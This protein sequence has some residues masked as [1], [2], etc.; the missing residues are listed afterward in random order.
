MNTNFNYFADA[1]DYANNN[2]SN[3][4]GGW[5]NFTDQYNYMDNA[6]VSAPSNASPSNSLP[7]V[8][9]IA[10]STASNVTGVVILGA[11][12]N[13]VGATNN[14]N[15]AAITITY[16]SGS[17]TYAQFLENL[18]S[19]P[20]KVGK[21]HLY[22]TN[23]SQ[24]FQTLTFT[25]PEPNGAS[26]TWPMVPQL[27]PLQNLNNV[28]ILSYQFSVNAMTLITT[29]ILASATLVMSLYPMEE[30]NVARGLDGRDV[31]KM[32]GAPRLSQLPNFNG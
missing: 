9:S 2:Y 32:Y 17:V 21:M 7:Y 18:K 15:A 31:A 30:M 13:T 1:Y 12:I 4:N 27:D 10:N 29:T 11:N 20:F 26:R 14:G 25:Q 3:A 6:G 24:P 19:N 16:S 8:F 28:T 5:D 23:A 22:S